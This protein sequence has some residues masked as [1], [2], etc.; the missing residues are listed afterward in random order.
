MLKE[1]STN[2][3]AVRKIT[4]GKSWYVFYFLKNC[5]LSFLYYVSLILLASWIQWNTMVYSVAFI[6]S[7]YSWPEIEIFCRL[8]NEKP[9]HTSA[10]LILKKTWVSWKKKKYVRRKIKFTPIDRHSLLK[11]KI[12]RNL[13]EIRSKKWNKLGTAKFFEK[14][15]LLWFLK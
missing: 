3:G 7:I 4:E 1:I 5:F 13:F 2:C 6:Y 8:S 10:R 14:F 11:Q 9:N 12:S 15:Y